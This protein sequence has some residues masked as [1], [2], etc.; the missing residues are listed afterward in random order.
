MAGVRPEIVTVDWLLALV[1]EP[2]FCNTIVSCEAGAVPLANE[3]QY[4]LPCSVSCV[5]IEMDER[6]LCVVM[7]TKSGAD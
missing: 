1:D 3:A 6:A 5:S 4:T 7:E 2:K